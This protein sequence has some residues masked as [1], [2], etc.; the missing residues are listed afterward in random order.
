MIFIEQQFQAVLQLLFVCLNPFY[1]LTHLYKHVLETPEIKNEADT[2]KKLQFLWV[3][4]YFS[5]RW[6]HQIFGNDMRHTAAKSLDQ[7]IKTRPR[8]FCVKSYDHILMCVQEG[9]VISTLL[10]CGGG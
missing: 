10:C 7:A 4:T 5:S 9:C 6:Q 8:L 2:A 3:H 1:S